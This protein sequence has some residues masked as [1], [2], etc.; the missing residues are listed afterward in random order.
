MINTKDLP[1][2]VEQINSAKTIVNNIKAQK[3]IALD[4]ADFSNYKWSEL[5][6]ADKDELL[7]LLAAKMGITFKAE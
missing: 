7:K 3:A 5:D 6:Q 2:K 4:L 1:E